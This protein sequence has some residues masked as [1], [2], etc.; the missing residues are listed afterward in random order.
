MGGSPII[1]K[2]PKH[3]ELLTLGE[4]C[5]RGGGSIQTGP[6]GS[7]LHASDYVPVGVPSIMPVNIGDN[8]VVEYGIERITQADATRLSKHRVQ[9]GDIIYSRRGDVERRAL[10]REHEAGWLCG[11]GCLRVRLGEGVVSPA[12]ASFYLGHPRVR[13]WIVRHA[14]G[15]TMPNL[16]TKIMYAIPFVVPPLSEQRAIASV[17]GGLDDKIELNQRMN[18]TLES[19]AAAVFKSWFVDFDPVR[20]KMDG[21]SPAGMDE[22]TAA[23]FPDRL[24]HVDGDLVPRG[25]RFTAL[26]EVLAILE[27]GARP[28]GG[29]R[30]I[31][32]GVP[33]V[34]AES[35]VGL[36]R[37]DFSKTK[38]VPVEFFE[39]MRKG[40]VE[41]RDVL[42]YKDGGRP[43][44]Y[45]PHVSMFGDGFPF[46]RCCINE[47]VYRLRSN[48]ISSQLFLYFWLTS[49]RLSDE[50]RRKGTG[51]AIPGLN[52]MAVKSLAM[53]VPP[54][55]VLAAFD[56]LLEPLIG[57]IF[58]NCNAS[59]TLTA[60]RDSLL[61][62]LL[63][64]EL[65]VHDVE[66]VVEAVV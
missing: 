38:F 35:I 5:K 7:Q 45:E 66:R 37:F 20:A 1:D 41:S 56:R 40:H 16:N 60:L 50:M 6:F 21:R 11:T 33:S 34:G 52:S 19:L 31:T 2:A 47:H 39:R 55:K 42:L 36:G 57:H 22:A 27:T 25:W 28:K 13:Q 23:Q 43:G 12:Y 15:A 3:W 4:I 58:A 51:V 59:K 18:A 29:V 10:V 53:L 49:D 64:G 48:M 24:E 30:G 62:K 46:E 17:L 63:S 54:A 61:P 65:R 44:L 26:A 14:V 9:P 32:E 8:R